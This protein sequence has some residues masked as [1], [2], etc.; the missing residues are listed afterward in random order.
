MRPLHRLGEAVKARHCVVLAG[1]R[2]RLR[3]EESLEHTDRFLE[4]VD[5]DTR[6]IERDPRAV[7][8]G[9]REAGSEPQLDAPVR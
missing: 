9:L 4:A 7:I 2:E 3:A 8:F 5:P 1:E 6:R